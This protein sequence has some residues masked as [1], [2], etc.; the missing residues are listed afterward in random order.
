LG[1]QYNMRDHLIVFMYRKK[2]GQMYFYQ[3][4]FSAPAGSICITNGTR[5]FQIYHKWYIG[6]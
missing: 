2:N 6:F 5:G 1:T 3:I 4:S